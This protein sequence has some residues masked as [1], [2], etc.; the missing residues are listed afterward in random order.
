MKKTVQIV[1]IPLNKEGY[2]KAL[3]DLG[4]ADN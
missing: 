3:K 4:Y 2:K 1:T